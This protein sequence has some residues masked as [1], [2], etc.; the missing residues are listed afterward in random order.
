[1][2]ISAAV[3]SELPLSP[4]PPS[5]IWF[6]EYLSVVTDGEFREVFAGR[7]RLGRYKTGDVVARNVLLVTLA[8][9]PAVHLGQLAQAFGLSSEAVRRIR[10][11]HEEKGMRA[12]V[13]RSGAGRPADVS[14]ETRRELER[15]FDQG[16]SVSAAFKTI[17]RRKVKSRSTVGRIR[18][19]WDAARRLAPA[20]VDEAVEAA[21][22]DVREDSAPPREP[23]QPLLA[24]VPPAA[25]E[26]AAPVVPVA[27]MESGRQAAFSEE[28]VTEVE[29]V[30]EERRLQRRA[31]ANAAHVQHLG[32]WLLIATTHALGLHRHAL[33]VA[34]ER[35]GQDALRLALDALLVALAVGQK[36]V[37]GVR[38]IATSTAGALLLATAAPSA[39]WTR[40]TLGRFAARHGAA[41]FQLSMT[42]EYLARG[43]AESSSE[44]PAYYVD[45]HLRA[46]TGQHTLR[47]G[48]KMQDKRAR[49]GATDYYAHDEDGRPVYRLVAPDHGALTDVLTQ[50]ARFLRQGHGPKEP[51]LIAF[52]RAGSFPEEMAQLRDEG[53]EFVTYE[54]RPYAALPKSAFTRRVIVHGQRL[55]LCEPAR[56]NLGRGRGRVR[57]ICVLTPDG[58]QLNLLAVSRR[59]ARRLVEILLGR[60]VQE[61]AFKHANERW[62]LNHLDGRRIQHYS[63][64]AIIPNPSRRRLDAALRLARLREGLARAE[65]AR[66]PEAAAQRAQ[67]EEDIREAMAAQQELLGERPTTP[68]HAPLS[69]TELAGRLVHHTVEYKLVLDTIRT[70]C[71]NAEAELA[72]L[73]SPHLPRPA[74]A[75]RALA[76]LFAAPGRIGVGRRRITVTLSPAAT[77]PERQA[78]AALFADINTRRLVMPADQER[79][80]LHFR[81]TEESQNL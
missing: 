72:A 77:A 27:A 11:L 41:L 65:L 26:P 40:R 74:E 80:S 76:N 67:V 28:P 52:D 37:E 38:R 4:S 22:V 61:N 35:V 45:N 44:G 34:G 63:P 19:G 39:T 21:P 51:I 25:L 46:Y 6:G 56:R 43:R 68:T 48:W 69:E 20:V 32:A 81:L 60:W 23:P 29:A 62:G 58:Q 18:K 33:A 59:P 13:A 66:L 54:R 75:K 30:A 17:G 78:F 42:R 24:V 57:C 7:Y 50:V 73:L 1:M 71:V 31:P 14:D 49:P 2:R 15:L 8:A 53:F 79:R 70:G 16:A 47:Q 5:T 3:T 9:D 12:V 10:R 64:D 36:C 55:G